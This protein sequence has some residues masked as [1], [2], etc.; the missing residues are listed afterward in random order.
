MLLHF[1]YTAS[2]LTF[3]ELPFSWR[4]GSSSFQLKKMRKLAS[5]V[6]F[7]AFLA[8]FTIPVTF[9]FSAS[10]KGL[11]INSRHTFRSV[12][13]CNRKIPSQK[14]PRWLLHFCHKLLHLSYI[15]VT[16]FCYTIIY[17]KLISCKSCNSVTA[18]NVRLLRFF[19]KIKI[20]CYGY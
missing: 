13:N 20:T 10:L 8:N 3:T 2:V 6:L 16:S 9:S 4:R 19:Q 15:L 5:P 7:S 1:C 17:Y 14:F 11:R 18:K 12:T